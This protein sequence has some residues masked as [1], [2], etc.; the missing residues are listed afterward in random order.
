MILGLLLPP[1]PSIL[2]SNMKTIFNKAAV[3]L[4]LA[5]MLTTASTGLAQVYYGVRTLLSEQFHTSKKVD[6]VRV[7][8]DASQK[9]A[10]EKQ[11]GYRLPRQEYI[12]Y[13]ART[14]GKIDGYAL[15]D[16]EIGQHEYIDFA[17]FFDARGKVTRV[18]VV[19]YR[20]PYGEGIRSKRFRKQ[21]V[22]RSASSGFRTGRDIDSI[23]GATLSARAMSKAVRR[24]SVILERA[25]LSSSTEAKQA[26]R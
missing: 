25:V 9:Q 15:F 7:Q 5:L 3:A 11:L 4:L 6:F 19:A 22:G 8:L 21:F 2:K 1:R 13:I 24:A 18:E 17:T 20:E 26:H 16:Q 23:T 10:L 14:E 12:F